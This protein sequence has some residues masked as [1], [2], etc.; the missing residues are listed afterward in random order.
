MRGASVFKIFV[1]DK[2]VLAE[3]VCSKRRLYGELNY[4]VR[5]REII[6]Y[7][8]IEKNNSFARQIVDILFNHLGD[9]AYFSDSQNFG[10]GTACRMRW[11]DNAA[12]KHGMGIAIKLTRS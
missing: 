4:L 1:N 12:M 8:G 6:Y 11:L 9:Q 3:N 7:V 10:I 2:I 5:F